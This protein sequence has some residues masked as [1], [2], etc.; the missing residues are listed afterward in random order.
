MTPAPALSSEHASLAPPIRVL[1]L[2]RSGSGVSFC[3]VLAAALGLIVNILIARAFGAS[4]A[5]DS[6]L[7]GSALPLTISGA[8]LTCFGYVLIPELVAAHD[9]PGLLREIFPA[10]FW[11]VLA[12]V[13][14]GWLGSPLLVHWTAPRLHA[15]KLELAVQVERGF[16]L[17]AGASCLSSFFSA[18]FQDRKVFVGPAASNLLIRFG[19]LSVLLFW[20]APTVAGLMWGYVVG[21][22]LQ[23]LALAWPL[24]RLL[25]WGLPRWSPASRRFFRKLMPVLLSILPTTLVPMIDAFWAAGLPDGALSFVGYDFRLTVTVVNVLV[26]GISAVIFPFLCD[27]AR[28]SGG[29][30]RF[31]RMLLLS[32]AVEIALIGPAV[33]AAVIWRRPL[34]RL[35]LEHGAF[36]GA[37]T[38]A[39]AGLLP[40]Y[41]IGMLGMS[42]WIVVGGALYARQR[43]RALGWLGTVF[44][45]VYFA[46]EG[47]LVGHLGYVACGVAFAVCWS[48]AAVAALTMSW[49]SLVLPAPA[50]SAAVA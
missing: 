2:V 30:R 9:K 43:Y 28:G 12:A 33:V 49:P 16:W 11:F 21:A 6:Y 32:L 19:M 1:R 25:H 45:L 42:T 47:L 24:R 20:I 4:A 3:A 34:I 17:A 44:S 13:L 15:G 37:S 46:M 41:L 18:I 7:T 10:L 50:V 22:L 38:T 36:T 29:E 23:T 39:V 40:F 27:H 8:M 14:L 35:L 48:G 31:R 5:F 26:S